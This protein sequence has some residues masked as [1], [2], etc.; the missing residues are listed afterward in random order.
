MPDVPTFAE[1]GYPDVNRT[2]FYG[3]IGPKGMSPELVDKINK[4]TLKVLQNP[5]VK[6]AH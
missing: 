5:D 3:I 4:A 2:A 1:V 6:K